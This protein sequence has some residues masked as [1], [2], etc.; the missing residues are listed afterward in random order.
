M[1]GASRALFALSPLPRMKITKV[2][3]IYVSQSVVRAHCDSGQDALLVKIT[4]DA[5]ITGFGEVDSAPLEVKAEAPMLPAE[6]VRR[7]PSARDIGPRQLLR[8]AC[9]RSSGGTLAQSTRLRLSRTPP[10]R[11]ST[12]GETPALPGTRSCSAR[13][14][15]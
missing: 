6:D 13:R 11:P 7:N 14:F 8:P 9:A 3:A 1:N 15:Q 4:T 10:P 12:A 2:E 5:G